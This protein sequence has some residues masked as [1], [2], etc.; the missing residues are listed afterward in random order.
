[1]TG[2]LLALQFFTVIPVK[3]E[4]PM[5][6]KN[7][8]MMYVMLPIVGFLIGLTMYA[9]YN[10]SIH[11]IGFGPLLTAVLLAVTGFTLTGG[12]HLDGW[13]DTADAFFSYKEPE[14]RFAILEDPRLGAFGTMALIFIVFMKVALFH[15]AISQQLDVLYALI[16]IPLI[17]RAL[18]NICFAT[19]PAGKRKGIAFYLKERLA[20][21]VVVISSSMLICI[22]LFLYA[23]FLGKWLLTILL[24]SFLLLTVIYFR[25]WAMK[26]FRG[27]TGD[28]AGAYI[29]GM[30][31]ILWLVALCLL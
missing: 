14:K 15:E 25:R 8:T 28:L 10:M 2:F 19:L 24:A 4:L 21:K 16:F 20:S 7:V 29:E 9:V 18:L 1:M 23:L 17:A 22:V 6:R 11:V 12:L 31:V 27:I 26:H 5:E 30:E 13:A 3:K